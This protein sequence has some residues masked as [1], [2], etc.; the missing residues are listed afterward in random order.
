M[1]M[2][3]MGHGGAPGV[4]HGGDA[5]LGAQVFGI[6]GDGDRRLRRRL[7]QQ[8]VDHR[9]ILVADVGDRRRQSVDDMEIADRQQL[10]LA[11]GQ[12][13][14]R[15]CRLALRTVSVT[16][17]VVSDDGVTTALVL[18]A[19]DVTTERRCAAALNRTHHLHLLE[20]DVAAVGR[21][22]SGAVV[23]ENVRDLQS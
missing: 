18:A 6:G 5:D 9:L 19:R 1:Q 17:T 8:I 15:G 3:M 12:P 14:A 20:A 21:T 4:E 10:R 23:A 22:P 13:L 16:A 2:R 7:E 11:F